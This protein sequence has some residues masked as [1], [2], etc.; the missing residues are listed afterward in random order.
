MRY[1]LVKAGGIS[2]YTEGTIYFDSSTHLLK[3]GTGS[4]SYMT[5]SGVRSAEYD[6]STNTLTIINQDGE[7]IELDLNV[8]ELPTVTSS[9]NHKVTA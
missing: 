4:N 5:Y 1:E 3:V 7:E 8:N 9:Y 6:T 2:T